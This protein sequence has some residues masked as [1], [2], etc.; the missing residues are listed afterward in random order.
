MTPLFTMTRRVEFCETDAAGIVHFSAFPLWMEQAEHAFWRSLGLSVMWHEQEDASIT[1]PRLACSSEFL[2][3][4]RFEDEVE[5][6]LAISERTGKTLTFAFQFYIGDRCLATGS[7]KTICCR[8]RA[9][10]KLRAIEIPAFIAE[11][12]PE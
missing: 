8:H 2:S 9:G 1:W 10:E 6:R 11:K 5:I 12:L 7:M 3:P 4:A